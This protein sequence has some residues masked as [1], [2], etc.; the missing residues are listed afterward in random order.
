M[1]IQL[2]PTFRTPQSSFWKAADHMDE[3]H[4]MFSTG[5]VREIE[6]QYGA[7]EGVVCDPAIV[8][9]DGLK[10]PP[11]RFVDVL[12]LQ[13]GLRTGMAQKGWYA[14]RL[15]RAGQ[16]YVSAPLDAKQAKTVQEWMEQWVTAEGECSYWGA[17]SADEPF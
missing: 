11:T 1:V 17:G 16:A 5:E 6:S 7:S 14:F 15:A 8:W 12:V 3:I 4:L 10:N 2:M 9:E 13:A